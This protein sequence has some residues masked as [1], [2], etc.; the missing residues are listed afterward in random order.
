MRRAISKLAI[1]LCASA[2]PAPAFAACNTLSLCSCTASASGIALGSYDPFSPTPVTSS[3]T[4]TVECTLSIALAGSYDI[5][6]ST[7]SS[8]SFAPRTM[9]NGGSA[10]NYN[11]YTSPAL[12]QVWG[13]GTAGS[14]QVTRSFTALLFV[15]QTTNIYA[16]IPAGQNVAAGSYAD[17]ITVTVTY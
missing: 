14:A 10:L 7:G 8:G 6:L 2:M 4:V 3:G 16:E 17:T 9:M 1:A 5:A 12:T 15:S 11:L 13:D